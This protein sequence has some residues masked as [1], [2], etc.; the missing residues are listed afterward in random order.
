MSLSLPG[1]PLPSRRT[2]G[3]VFEQEAFPVWRPVQL[4]FSVLLVALVTAGALAL[5]VVTQANLVMFYLLVVVFA[6]SRWGKGPAALAAL[7]SVLAFD[8]FFVPPYQLLTF[9]VRDTEHFVTFVCFMVVGLLVADWTSRIRGLARDRLGLL[10]EARAVELLREKERLQDALLN[11][12]SH[13]LQT[14][15]SS[16]VGAL[17]GLCDTSINLDQE[18]R[19][20]LLETA[21]SET[22]RLHRLVRNLLDLTR[23]ESGPRLKFEECDLTDLVGTALSQLED[24]L[25]ARQVRLDFE[26]E[27]PVLA[28]DFVLFTQVLVNLIDNALKYSPADSAIEL[29]YRTDPGGVQVEV[30]DRG[31]GIAEA[32]RERVFEKFFRRSD[33][34]TSGSGLGLAI[35]RGLVEAHGGRLTATARP[36]GGTSLVIWLPTER[37]L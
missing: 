25:G 36:G 24:A 3:P 14:P 17:D 8:F 34:N 1:V 10:E 30:L 21:R 15:I 26:P 16:I 22:H 11:S 4:L 6:A 2:V 20:S 13:D 9:S 12:I 29:R 23:L 35:S 28:V 31:G 7:M 18:S 33:T 5:G 19:Q 27:A 32:D 37:S